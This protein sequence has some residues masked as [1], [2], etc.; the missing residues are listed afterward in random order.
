MPR[1]TQC[2]QC[3]I[4][5]NLPENAGGKRLKCPKC[6][7]KFVVGP[8][9][10]QYPATERSDVDAR[11]ASSSL[12]AVG[13]PRRFFLADVLGGSERYVRPAVDDRGRL[14]DRPARP[15]PQTRPPMP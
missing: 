4:I 11:A 12:L 5:L 1:T 15:S 8:D 7:T 13:R 14:R 3:G 9:S 6:G 10:S 2:N